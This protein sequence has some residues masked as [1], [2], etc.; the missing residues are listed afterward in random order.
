MGSLP[1][2]EP[3]PGDVVEPMTKLRARISEHMVAS[4]HTSAAATRVG[5]GMK[6]TRQ[7]RVPSSAKRFQI[8]V[9]ATGDDRLVLGSGARA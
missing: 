3:W 4:R 8:L 9:R 5:T 6:R 1:L 2:P 7:K